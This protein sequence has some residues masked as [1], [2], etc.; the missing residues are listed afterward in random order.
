M[1]LIL[2]ILAYYMHKYV[3]M[4]STYALCYLP[5][6]DKIN[7][8][9]I[10]GLALNFTKSSTNFFLQHVKILKVIAKKATETRGFRP[11]ESTVT[12]LCFILW[13]CTLYIH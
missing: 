9:K 12:L 4:H 10:R 1:K 11:L 8:E 2:L 5:V 3:C 7:K 13:Q 6:F